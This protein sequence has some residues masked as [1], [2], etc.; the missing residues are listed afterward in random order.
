MPGKLKGTSCKEDALNTQEISM[1]WDICHSIRDRFIVGCMVLAGLRVSELV[2]LRKSWVNFE[3]N[4]I[5][6]PT[7]QD[8]NCN[9]CMKKRD[10]KW[11][12]KTR[13]GARTIRIHPQLRSILEEYLASNDGLNL[14]RQRVWQR[15]KELCRAALILHNTY[16][17]CLRSTCAIELAHEHISSAALQYLLGWAKLSSAEAYV[18]SDRTRALKEYDDIFS[19]GQ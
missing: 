8:C 1:L 15:I 10:G 14:T 7:R 9:E 12:P 5:T 13:Q 3:E 6:V 16:P 2:H 11:K 17:H 4:T 18:R 19:I